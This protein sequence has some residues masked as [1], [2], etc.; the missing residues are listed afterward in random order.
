MPKKPVYLS[1][2]LLLMLCSCNNVFFTEPQPV[3]SKNSYEFPVKY[4]G[5]WI[6]DNDTIFINKYAYRS[7]S[8]QKE[9][10]PKAIADTSSKYVM[11]RGRIYFIQKEEQIKLI[12]GFPYQERNDTIFYIKREVVD[13]SLGGNTFLRKVSDKHIFNTK[14]DDLWWNIILIEKA[15]DGSILGRQ[16]S[17]ND[18]ETILKLKPIWS[19]DNVSYFDIRWS[20]D[21]I[22]KI[23]NAGCFSDTIINLTPDCRIRKQKRI[24]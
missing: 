23:I 12:G 20:E 13:V 10:L 15:K 2:L 18:M 8:Y 5:T 16:L 9:A 7:V 3:D 21:D 19:G 22:D 1:L 17:D 14:S 4:Q 6:E 24:R 11:V